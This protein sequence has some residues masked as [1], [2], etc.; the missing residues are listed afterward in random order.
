MH[1]KFKVFYNS[2]FENYTY[3]IFNLLTISVLSQHD[4]IYK[5]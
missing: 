2:Y 3:M 5:K 4:N 1:D